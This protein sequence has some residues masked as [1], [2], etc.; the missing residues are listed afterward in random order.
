MTFG[1]FA[2]AHP[3]AA[4]DALADFIEP[5]FELLAECHGMRSGAL[6]VTFEARWEEY[7]TEH[8]PDTAYEAE[9]S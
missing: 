2:V 6:G 9:E 1:E 8:A 5:I 4:D 3:G 7:W